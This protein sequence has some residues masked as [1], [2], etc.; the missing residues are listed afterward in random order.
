MCEKELGTRGSEKI[1]SIYLSIYSEVLL[2]LYIQLG[3]TDAL[4][5]VRGY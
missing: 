4:L 5:T 3:V 2:M 1:N